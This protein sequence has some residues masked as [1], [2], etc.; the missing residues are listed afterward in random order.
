[1]DGV[2]NENTGNMTQESVVPNPDSL[3][4]VRV[5]QDNFSAQYSLLGSSVVLMQ[6]K[7]GTSKLHGTVWEYVR[8][9]KFNSKPYY[10]VSPIIPP[11]KQNI[12]GFNVG[13]PIFIPHLY[14]TDRK[15]TFFFWDE[16]YVILH[17][18]NQVTSQL[19]TPNQIAGCFTTPVKDPVSG[20]VLPD[21]G[22]ENQHQFRGVPDNA[23][24]GA[25]LCA[26]RQH[27]EL[28]QQPGAEDL[29]ARRSDQ[30][31][32]LLLAELPSAGRVLP[33]VP[34]LRAEYCL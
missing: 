34:G 25:R 21:S 20:H 8:N 23:V 1:V 32:S 10:Q 15:K 26:C 33:G 5:L 11:Y 24:S 3:E 22:G 30:G 19:P 29:S 16:S 28:H 18:P 7:S 9:D 13:G 6:T 31:R 17:V 4:E 12:F 14:N 2:W 27:P